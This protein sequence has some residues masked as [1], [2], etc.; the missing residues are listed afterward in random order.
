MRRLICWFAGHKWFPPVQAR[1]WMP[2]TSVCLRCPATTITMPYGTCLGGHPVVDHYDLDG[3]EHPLPK[4][5]CSTVWA[6]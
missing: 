3:K 1:E 5:V 6:A 4:H 2:A